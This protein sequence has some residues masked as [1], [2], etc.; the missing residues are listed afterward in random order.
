MKGCI[1][2]FLTPC[3]IFLFGPTQ[4]CKTHFTKRLIENINGGMFF[5]QPTK[6]VYAYTQWQPIFESLKDKVEFFC[7]LP[8]K[9]KLLD[10]AASTKKL[11]L[12]LDD[13]INR[14]IQSPDYL[15]LVTIH[16]HHM[17]ISVVYISQ[18]LFPQG[19]FSRT[20]SLNSQNI[21]LFDNPRDTLQIQVLARKIFPGKVKYFL[22]CF[23]KATQNRYCYLLIDI[24]TRS[25]RRFSFEREYFQT[26]YQ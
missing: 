14:I 5:Q 25:D 8:E 20:I 2:S 24:S 6:N 19:R 3:S 4:S 7:G 15:E 9:E 16:V 18:N 26:E 10:W 11:L 17:N 22:D 21:V 13:L 23:R 1:L 12:I